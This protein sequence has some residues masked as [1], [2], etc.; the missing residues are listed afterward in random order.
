MR[1]PFVAA[2]VILALVMLVIVLTRLVSFAQQVHRNGFEGASKPFWV[3][4]GTDAAFEEVAH[5]VTDQ[6]AHDGQ[7][8]EYIQLQ[9]KNGT[10]IY[11]QYA[12]GKAPIG[13]EF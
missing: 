6:V 13:P 10:Y 5:S 3:K 1:I 9:A 11:Y 4:G 8:S 2:L 7:R 12:C